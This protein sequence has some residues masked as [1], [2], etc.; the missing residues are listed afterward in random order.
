MLIGRFCG[1][2]AEVHG[3]A[4]PIP[5]EFDLRGNVDVVLSAGGDEAITLGTQEFRNPGVSSALG[6]VNMRYETSCNSHRAAGI[7][8]IWHPTVSTRETRLGSDEAFSSQR[9][10]RWKI[11][12]L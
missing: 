7:N 11:G 9:W 3:Q 1:D 4:K 2:A 10:L 5:I 12:R 6:F 8:S